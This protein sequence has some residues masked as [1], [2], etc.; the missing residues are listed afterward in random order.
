[1]QF[2][3]TSEIKLIEE[4]NDK[5]INK[6]EKNEDIIMKKLEYICLDEEAEDAKEDEDKK[7]IPN[8]I[9]KGDAKGNELEKKDEDEIKKSKRKR[10]K[11]NKK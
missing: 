6:E 10:R 4:A 9:K 7:D 3:D 5:E 11:K 1:M 8:N 2:Y